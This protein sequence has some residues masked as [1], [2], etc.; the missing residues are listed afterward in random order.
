MT[1][2]NAATGGRGR[3]LTT[4][5]AGGEVAKAMD[6]AQA[7]AA[8]GAA[9]NSGGPTG[10]AG[11]PDEAPGEGGGAPVMAD[12]GVAAMRDSIELAGLVLVGHLRRRVEF[13]EIGWEGLGQVDVCNS[14]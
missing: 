2:R 11:R 14:P 1:A 13:Y 9:D 7:R 10:E 8:T 12:S 3:W 5:G 6:Q 4:T